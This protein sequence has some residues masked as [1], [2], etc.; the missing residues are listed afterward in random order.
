MQKLYVKGVT[1]CNL[2][3]SADEH[4]VSCQY[5]Y[6]VLNSESELKSNID[7]LRSQSLT[8]PSRFVHIVHQ[9]NGRVVTSV[10]MANWFR[11]TSLTR[12][13]LINRKM[14][15]GFLAFKYSKGNKS[16]PQNLAKQNVRHYLFSGPF[17][18]S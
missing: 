9:R 7:I 16:I 5:D 15:K 13:Q 6:L 11:K 14:L 17:H 4:L 10:L 1:W 2:S 8:Q 12:N 18:W 3:V